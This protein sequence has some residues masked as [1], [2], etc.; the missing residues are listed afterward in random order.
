M[1]VAIARDRYRAPITLETDVTKGA[2]KRFQ[3]TKGDGFIQ[4]AAGGGKDVF[5]HCSPI[6]PA[7]LH[8]LAE[9]RPAGHEINSSSGRESAVKPQ[10][11]VTALSPPP[12]EDAGA[13]CRACGACCS[14][15]PE[16]PR[17]ST[18]DDAALDRIPSAYVDNAQGRMRCIGNRCAALVGQVGVATAC[19]IYAMRPDVCKA[20]LPGDE[21][22]QMARRRFNLP[23][24][25]P[26]GSANEIEDAG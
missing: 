8:C 16:W 2:V 19:A 14:F 21:A 3:P 9:G 20:C 26:S 11:Q 4:P 23:P 12:G 17:F 10:G 25:A 13:D 5:I 22:C 15:S 24:L 6:E 7:P 18:E 1:L